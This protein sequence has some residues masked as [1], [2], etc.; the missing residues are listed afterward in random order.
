VTVERLLV[1]DIDGTLLRRGQ[2]TVGLATLTRMIDHYEPGTRLV[3]ATGRSIRSVLSQIEDGTLPPAD[4]VAALV[5][6][7]VWFSPWARPD[8]GFFRRIDP[9]WQRE[10][11][12]DVVARVEGLELQPS[13]F[14]S[15]RKLSFFVDGETV[16]REVRS[17]LTL[18]DLRCRLIYSGE[19]YLDLIPDRAGKRAAVEYITSAWN[20]PGAKVLAAGDSLNDRDM[21]AHPRYFGVVVANADED[22]AEN[23]QGPR[24]HESSLPFAAG[25]LEGAEFFD[26]WKPNRP[27]GSS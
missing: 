14:Q 12:R 8:G 21:L 9:G 3:Y 23:V 4:A 13:E 24:L 7:E 5:G 15:P 6:T 20:A 17:L 26:F 27:D 18:A 1:S 2:P 19:R 25:V 16:V 10:R 22:L 11:I